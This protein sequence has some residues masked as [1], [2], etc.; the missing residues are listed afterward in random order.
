MES[1]ALDLVIGL[2]VF[3]DR[4]KDRIGFGSFGGLTFRA[5]VAY[6]AYL[7]LGWKHTAHGLDF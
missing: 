2:S 6:R 7:R 3:F 5:L 4:C 1:F